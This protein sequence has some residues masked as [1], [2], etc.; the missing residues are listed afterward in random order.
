VADVLA[1]AVVELEADVDKANKELKAAFKEMDKE[2]KEAAKDIDKSFQQLS[3]DLGKEFRE[4]TKKLEREFRQQERE[5]ARTARQIERE[6]ARTQR[7]MERE[8]IRAQREIERETK[9]VARANERAQ[10]E[11]EREFIASQRAMESA[12]R[13]SQAKQAEQFRNTISAVRRFASERF[14]LTLGIDSSQVAGALSSVTKLGAALGVLGVG[15]LAGQASLAGLASITV[16]VQELVGA[17]ALRPAVGAAAG[18]VVGTLTLGLRGLSDAISADS[19]EEFAEALKGLSDNGKKF[20]TVVRSL[21]DEFKEL[22][23]SVQQAL[24]ANLSDEVSALAKTLL[25]TLRTGFVETAKEINLSARAFAQFVREGQTV[26]D[27]DRIF[28]NTQAAIRVFRGAIVPAGQALRDLAAVGSDFL[29][30]ISAELRL[31]TIK[32]ADFIK[33]ARASGDLHTFFENAIDAVRDLLAVV[34]NVASIFAAI[35]RAANAALGGGFLDMLANATQKVEDFLESAEG[36]TA[37]IQLF[38]GAQEAVKALLPVFGELVRLILEVILP[39]FTKLGTIAAE[40]LHALLQGLRSGL[41]IALPGIFAFVEALGDV[42]EVLV[43]AGVLDSLGNLVNVLGDSLGDALRDLA[44]DLANLVNSLLSTL[45]R[46]LPKILPALSK[47]ASAFADLVIAALPVVDVLAS[48]ISDVGLPTLQRIAERLAPIISDLASSL[49]ETLLPILPDL[50]DAFIE[51]IDAMAPLVDDI[52]IIFVDLLKILVPLLPAI[53]RG[54]AELAK[55]LAPILDLFVKIVKPISEFITKLYEIPSV[56]KF[57]DE[58]LPGLLA[59]LMGTIIVPIGKIIELLGKLFTKLED[60]GAFDIFILALDAFGLAMGTAADIAQRF[61]QIV[62]DVFEFIKK[63]I[64]TA[65]DIIVLVITTGLTVIST[66]FSTIWETIKTIVTLA[67]NILIIIIS[68][69]IQLIIAILTGNFSAIPTI[70]GNAMQRLREVVGQAF[71]DLLNLIRELP[72]RI[73]SALGNLGSLLYGAGR[74]LVNGMINGIKSATSGLIG[75]AAN[76]AKDALNAAKA[77]IG[78]KSPSREMMRVGEDFGQ[79]FVIGIDNMLRKAT[80]ASAD[81]AAQ[82][83]TA[84]TT[85]LAPSD[86]A[87]FR[88][89]ETLNRLTR[90]GFGPTATSAPSPSG[91]SEL[92]EPVVVAPEIHVFIGNEEIDRHVTEVVDE[93]DRRTKRSLTM[94]ARRTL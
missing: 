80:Q 26:K 13:E 39:A 69:A 74:D 35:N 27:I 90:N 87:T 17:I 73:L 51:W 8:A 41:E 94:G 70:I 55:T 36:Q 82:T 81:L 46:I 37:L 50:A 14:S 43:G 20:V 19:P 28:M 3:G 33:E 62:Q 42:V 29:P 21:K 47:F 2:A 24:L 52:L 40:P 92:S 84:S 91:T 30:N 23:K 77:A 15:A 66:I 68:T 56:K 72:G 16:A 34:G 48:I 53:V 57:L 76:M 10:K 65:I 63:V 75:A 11:Y 22:G 1:E 71:N 67:W 5:A 38:E 25:P 7:A 6:Y 60:T 12:A 93:R 31:A 4:I 18:V 78:A 89:N 32:F 49:E 79:G 45:A 88:M 59:L 83:V 44:P 54:S 9:R 85:A 86:N 61:G 58:Q 64:Q